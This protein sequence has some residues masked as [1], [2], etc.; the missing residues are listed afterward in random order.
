MDGLGHLTISRKLG[1]K[2]LI[3]DNIWVQV[4]EID[5]GKIRLRISAPRGVPIMREELIGLDRPGTVG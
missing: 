2:V 4:A 1:E 5:R 3:G